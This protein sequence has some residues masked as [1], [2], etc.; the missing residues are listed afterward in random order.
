MRS[1]SRSGSWRGSTAGGRRGARDRI[2]VADNRSPSSVNEND[3]G[4]FSSIAHRDRAASRTHTSTCRIVVGR[5][6]RLDAG[7]RI[8]P[9]GRRQRWFMGA[10]ISSPQRRRS[11]QCSLLVQSGRQACVPRAARC[12]MAHASGE[13][14]LYSDAGCCFLP[15][16]PRGSKLTPLQHRIGCCL[17][18][19]RLLYANPRL[20]SRDAP[21]L[22]SCC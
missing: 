13:T 17:A 11:G 22:K 16:R 8:C 3:L 19:V 20:S 15:P 10:R 12:R 7:T 6:R 14:G 18:V 2:R 9:A 5:Q 21:A 1:Q 4:R